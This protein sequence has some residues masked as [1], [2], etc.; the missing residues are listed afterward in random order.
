MKSISKISLPKQVLFDTNVLIYSLDS[1]SPQF[2]AVSR[3]FSRV[4]DGEIEAVIA[5]QNILE[6]ENVLTSYYKKRLSE[7]KYALENI[8]FSFNFRLICPIP[9][10]ISLYHKLAQKYSSQAKIDLYDIYLASTAL[11]NEVTTIATYNGKHFE[12]LGLTLILPEVEAQLREF[13]DEE[14][15]AWKK[16]DK[17]D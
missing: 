16:E 7:A 12:G 9:S 5:Q 14:I 4:K 1:A 8:I 17:L 2:E 10:T 3:L 15:D 11:S 13:T 6:V